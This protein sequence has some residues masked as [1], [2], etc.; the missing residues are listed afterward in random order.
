M[1]K[2][3]DYRHGKVTYLANDK[4][5]GRALSLYGEREEKEVEFV[6]SL[7]KPGDLVID[8][9]ANIGLLTVPMAQQGA[10]VLAFEPQPKMFELLEENVRQNNLS[11]V[12][13]FQ[14]GLGE[15]FGK[16]AIP[17]IDYEA[18]GNFG[19]VE[20]VPGNEVKIATLD[21]FNLERCDLIKADVEGMEIDVLR[22]AAATIE[23]FKPLLYLENDRIEKSAA[24][25]DFVYKLG[26]EMY[27]HAP[28]LYNPKNF[29]GIGE[30]IFPGTVT[31]NMLCVPKGQ[32]C[33]Q[34][35][36]LRP[37]TSIY[38]R[39]SGFAAIPP[40]VKPANG[41]AAVVRFGGIGDN[42]MAASACYALKKKGL[43]V[44]VI[45]TQSAQWQ[46]FQH[47]PNIDKLSIKTNGMD[48]PKMGSLDWQKWFRGRSDEYDVFVS[49]HHSCE[50]TLAFF[51]AMTQFHWPAHVRRKLADH[52]YLEFIHD[53]AGCPY[54]FGPLFY[55]TAEENK[56]ALE[57]KA[58]VG[59]RCIAVVISGTRVDK[60]HP[61]L[62][63]IVARLIS[64]LDAPVVV[65][66]SEGN[67]EHA[68]IL[69]NHVRGNN[70]SVK[71]FHVA[72]SGPKDA[73]G[74]RERDWPVRRTLAFAQVCDLVIGP[75]T[76]IMWGVA[77]EA[78]PKI[79]LLG[80]ASEKNITKHWVNCTTLHADASVACW[81]C[82]L[83]HDDKPTPEPGDV[84]FCTP[85]AENSGAACISSISVDTIIQHARVLWTGGKD[86]RRV[87]RRVQVDAR[88][89][90]DL[91]RAAK[92]RRASLQDPP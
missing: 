85:N 36:S 50:G 41:W 42:L 79:L 70:G 62:P 61:R 80:H 34:K 91:H 76:G 74:H 2:T 33:A 90:Q 35:A 89:A 57:T 92:G 13:L 56:A 66:G 59:E 40:E 25:I 84:S 87:R 5:I 75:D 45:T 30:N 82:H 67:L 43:K 26:Y 10:N 31:I 17:S 38:D 15:V 39:E 18:E 6:C 4:Y 44:E 83:L 46:V 64:E 65:L 37:I 28:Y 52:N 32:A 47:N 3:I 68:K 55:A 7:I 78:V 48:M 60:L 77:M 14:L 12:Q 51:P 88:R 29:N 19:G 1:K 53:I 22:G 73:K 8:V 20:L 81:P 24:L 72:I 86:E 23:R 58:K 63:S 69:E 9:G 49:L 11:G 21:S 16:A 54:D 71:N 27:W